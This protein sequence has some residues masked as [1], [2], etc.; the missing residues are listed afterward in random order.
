MQ[1]NGEKSEVTK[2]AASPDKRHLA[3]GYNDGTIRVFDIYTGELKVTF[4]GHKSAISALNYH[5]SGMTLV[6][7]SKV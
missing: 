7:G 4:S 2:L 3:V 6:S 5:Q 1:L